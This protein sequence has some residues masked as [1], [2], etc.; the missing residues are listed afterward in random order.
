MHFSDSNFR[1]LKIKQLGA[2]EIDD[3]IRAL[4]FDDDKTHLDVIIELIEQARTNEKA[5]IAAFDSLIKME[6]A[7][8]SKRV[9]E[10]DLTNVKLELISGKDNTYQLKLDVSVLVLYCH[11]NII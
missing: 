1:R 9:A 2:Y 4:E 7:A 10:Y 6:E 5:Y 8:H 3:K 11:L